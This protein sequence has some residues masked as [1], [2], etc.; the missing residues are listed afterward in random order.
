MIVSQ[1]KDTKSS[2]KNSLNCKTVSKSNHSMYFQAYQIEIFYQF[3][4][5]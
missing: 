3:F 2:Q 4:L 5:C 1:Q